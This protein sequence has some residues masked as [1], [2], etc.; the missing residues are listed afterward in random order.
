MVW[1]L[2]FRNRDG[3]FY[4]HHEYGG[5]SAYR[6][7]GFPDGNA[8]DERMVL[9][10]LREKA[11]EIDGAIA[12]PIPAPEAPVLLASNDAASL[13]WRGS[14]G[15]RS[16]TVE[17]RD[18]D[19]SDWSVVGEDID[20]ARFQYRPLFS[21]ESAAI[22]RQYFYRVA[23]KNESG[24]SDYSNTIGPVAVS[25]KTLVDEMFSFDRVFQKD[26]ELM[27]L[28]HQDIR[29]AKEDRSRLTGKEGSYIMYKTPGDA[30]TIKIDVVC[31]N[32]NS[33]VSVAVDSALGAFRPV[34]LKTRRFRFGA[35]DYGFFDAVSCTSD[36][37]PSG[38]RFVKILLQD[39][40]QICRVEIAY[41]SPS[42]PMP[43]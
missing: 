23:A 6:W 11:Y 38:T 35:N 30:W 28:T 8:Y 13:S 36:Q 32:E 39:G 16:Y 21:D 5:V 15:A 24:I 20:D 14:V 29:R 41:G 27:L 22:G 18:A 2:R 3:G 12:P 34:A 10:I 19:S 43:K 31:P 1:S 26:G 42:T 40:V 9:S 37:L 25:A 4:C 17:R 7:P 33:N